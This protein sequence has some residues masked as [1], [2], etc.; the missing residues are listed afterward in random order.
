MLAATLL[1]S[2]VGSIDVRA[3]E[4]VP[5]VTT[6]AG[7]GHHGERDG[8]APQF[9]LP[10]GIFAA[11]G[12]LYVADTFNNLIRHVNLE[13]YGTTLAGNILGL[14]AH[15]FP[16]GLF[17]DGAITN[18]LFNRP[19]DVA[20]GSGGNLWILDGAN[21][22]VRI[23][24]QQ[25]VYT[26]AGN[27]QP[28]HVNGSIAQA[29]FNRPSAMAVH[30]NGDVFI[31]DSGNHV[32]RRVDARGNVTTIAGVPEVYG[33][34]DG[35]ASEALFNGPAGIAVDDEGRI[36]VADTG[37]HLIRMIYNGDVTTIAGILTYADDIDF[38]ITYFED[39]WDNIP[40]GGFADGPSDQAMFNMP[41]GLAMWDDILIIA[42]TANHRIRAVLPDG[43]V[44]T[45]AGDGYAGHD[46]G[47]LDG[48]T[49][50]LPQGV[51][52]FGNILYISDTGN[53]VIRMI[54]LSEIDLG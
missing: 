17:R 37:N 15:R 2:A 49:F 10:V 12:G 18:T 27:G 51:S 43:E 24:I 21:H 16:I 19:S 9:N 47:P 8:E 25:N 26:V 39:E 35:Q 48:A 32:I 11:S 50:H 40:M 41:W 30:S 3:A 6:L 14:D 53:N 28:G 46:D 33:H 36:F 22:A 34:N 54:D 31:A 29:M 52:I 7:T 1:F 20:I 38:E 4:G 45:I 13:G 42:D 5:E 23:V 44:V